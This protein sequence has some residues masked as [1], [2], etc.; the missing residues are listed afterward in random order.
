MNL[1]IM[2][3]NICSGRDAFRELN[4]HSAEN[5]IRNLNPDICALNEVRM[6]TSDING[7]EQARQLGEALG[8][9]WAFAPAIQILGGEYGVAMLSRYPIVKTDYTPVPQVPVELRKKRYED[10]VLLRC[11]I[12]VGRPLAVYTSHFGLTDDEQI[13]ATE[14]ALSKLRAETL[15]AVLMGDFNM[16]PDHPLIRKISEQLHD[17]ADG[18]TF[19]TFHAL[20]PEIKI[21]YTF[22]TREFEIVKTCSP[23]TT[24]SDHFPLVADVAI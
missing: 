17:A 8:M 15:P 16:T 14:L 13:N 7:C 1:R 18:Q 24:A 4:L 5:A 9:Y 12:D 2:T 21:D 10:R 11:E 22:F 23:F 6:R 19:P 3:Y 20:K